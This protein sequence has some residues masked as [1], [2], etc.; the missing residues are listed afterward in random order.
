MIFREAQEP[1]LHDIVALLADDILG[2]QRE[3]HTHPVAQEYVDA[4]HA[5]TRQDGNRLIV[6]VD[7][8]GDIK[9]CLQLTITAGLARRGMARTTIEG[10][11]V[12]ADQRGSGLGT[13]LF[14]YAIAEAR[15]A[16]CG[17]VQLTTDKTRP[18][19]HRFYERL[20]FEPS[21][22]GMKLKL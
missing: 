2:A 11:R 3:N 5:L 21:H 14:E 10:V 16:N 4:F 8:Q 22:V 7:E 18:D 6:A 13:A 15:K 20:G 9:G 12:S 17:L 19:A 1:D